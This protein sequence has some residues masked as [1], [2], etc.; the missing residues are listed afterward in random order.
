MGRASHLVT[1]Q[2]NEDDTDEAL[3][4]QNPQLQIGLH[5]DEHLQMPSFWIGHSRDD[6]LIH[7]KLD[8]AL[9]ITDPRPEQR[10]NLIQNVSMVVGLARKLLETV[11]Y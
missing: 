11:L 5:V 10:W 1:W 6:P 7:S 4:R 2:G 9:A 3:Y 8:H